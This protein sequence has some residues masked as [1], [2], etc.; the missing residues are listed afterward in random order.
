MDPISI[1]LVEDDDEILSC[2]QRW[3]T[4]KFFKTISY[5]SC[6]F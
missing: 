3:D 6:C 1:A 4:L 5:N 2:F